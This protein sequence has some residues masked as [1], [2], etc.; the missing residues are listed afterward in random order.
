MSSQPFLQFYVGDYLADTTDLSCEEHGAYLLLLMTMWRHGAKLPNDPVRLARVARLTPRKWKRVWPTI[1]RY[2]EDD[3][4]FIR[5]RRLT[6]EHQKATEKSEL[7]ATAGRQG[8]IAKSLKNNDTPLAKAS[9]L[10]KHGQ[11]QKTEP[12][13]KGGGDS[14]REGDLTRRETILDLLGLDSSG[15]TGRGSKMLGGAE[16]MRIADK[17]SDDLGLTYGEQDQIIREVMEAKRDP[18]PPNTFAYFNK[19]MQRLAAAKAA[20]PLEPDGPSNV[21]PISGGRNGRTEQRR[22]DDAAIKE[23]IRRIREGTIDRGPDP[24]D[25]GSWG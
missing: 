11:N 21:T 16:D 23:T 18:G 2:F 15:L 20:P 12:D 17:W 5:N 14:A 7:R 6:K 22:R 19:A 1:S 3:G 4:E 9:G 13:K 25:P 8:G 24:S 10:L